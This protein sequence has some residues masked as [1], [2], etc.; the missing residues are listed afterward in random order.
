M[1]GKKDKSHENPNIICDLASVGDELC[2][3]NQGV[4]C[5]ATAGSCGVVFGD[6]AEGVSFIGPLLCLL[7]GSRLLI[8]GLWDNP[9]V[10]CKCILLLLVNIESCLANSKAG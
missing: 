3:A 6:G 7:G 2:I 8:V 9:S 1:Q 5:I 4:K 10:C